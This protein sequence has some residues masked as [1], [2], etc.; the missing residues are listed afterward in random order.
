[1]AKFLDQDGLS[2]LLSKLDGRYAT[3]ENAE[4]LSSRITNV[5]SA[6]NT[7]INNLKNRFNYQ[8]YIIY[9]SSQDTTR[10]IQINKD[11]YTTYIIRMTMA[12]RPLGGGNKFNLYIGPST[13]DKPEDGN[14]DISYYGHN[15][16]IIHFDPVSQTGSGVTN[17]VINIA[18]HGA[19]GSGQSCF[20]TEYVDP[21]EPSSSHF[22]SG[23]GLAISRFAGKQAMVI[24]DIY[25]SPQTQTTNSIYPLTIVVPRGIYCHYNITS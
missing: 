24:L 11:G 2:H 18:C 4:A 22:T 13:Q 7:Q 19:A 3:I 10:N 20:V 16:V 14:S 21:G 5:Q 6:A 1:M 12:Q 17:R 23:T 8:E 25:G 15:R 9:N